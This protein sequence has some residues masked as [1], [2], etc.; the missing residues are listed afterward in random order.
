FATE[1]L[2]R[3]IDDV[4][5][6]FDGFFFGRYDLRVQDLDAFAGGRGFKIVELNGVTSEATH[7]YDPRHSLLDAWRTLFRQ[8]RL[9]FEIG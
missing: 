6:G 5:S 3:R 4:S 1:A 2:E 9:A 7:I 8:W